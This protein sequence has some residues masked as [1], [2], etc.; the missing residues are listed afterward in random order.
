M[1]NGGETEALRSLREAIRLN[2][3]NV[4]AHYELG[5]ALAK[6]KQQ[7]E[8][9]AEFQKAIELDPQLDT[10]YFQLGRIYLA[11]GDR[12]K[13]QTYL[14]TSRDLKEKRR[15]ASEARLSTAP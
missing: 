4:S 9:V 1:D 5:K 12:A 13:A 6:R 8:A 15:A 7:T 3:T 11:A 10:A 2:P 14:D